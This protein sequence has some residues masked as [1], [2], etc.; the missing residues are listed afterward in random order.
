MLALARK[1]PRCQWYLV[2]PDRERWYLCV[3]VDERA[4]G[5]P[6]ELESALEAW[7]SERRLSAVVVRGADGEYQVEGHPPSR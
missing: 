1:L 7:L 3:E 4:G 2:Q 6:A 5:F